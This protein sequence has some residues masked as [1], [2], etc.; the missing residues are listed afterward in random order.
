MH[1]TLLV[2]GALIPGEIAATLSASLNAPNLKARLVRAALIEETSFAGTSTAQSGNAH[3]DWL[4]R[5]LFSQPASAPTAP[6]AYAQ[7][8]GAIPRAS[9]WHADPV[10]VEIARDHLIVQSLG[11]D[12]PAADE[13]APLINTANKLSSDLGCEFVSVGDR[14]FLQS[15]HDWVIDAAPLAAVIE[16]PLIM[17]V[18]NDAQVW[19]RLHN[20]IQMAWHAHSVNHARDAG[21]LRTINGIWLY[22]GGRWKPLLPIE[23]AQVQSDALEW[24]GAAQAAGAAGVPLN[25]HVIDNALLV[26]DDAV[27]PNRLTEWAAWLQAMMAIDRRLAA[28]ASDAIDLVLAGRSVRTFASRPSDR[29]KRWRRRTLADALTE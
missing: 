25:A 23:Y 3:L 17:P 11:A 20:E 26:I 27:L 8:S 22:G 9:I 4:A 12:A 7:L 6:Y 28:H 18:G 19:N 10:H 21:Q 5:R 29:Y 24:R 13:S 14:W 2:A 1:F 15:E 16:A